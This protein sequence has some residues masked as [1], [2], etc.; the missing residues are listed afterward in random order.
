MTAGLQRAT[1]IF[2]LALVAVFALAAIFAPLIAPYGFAQSA[3]DGVDF[4]RQQAPSAQ[5]WFGTSVRGE[6]VFSRVIWGARTALFVIVISLVLSLF[7]GVPLGLLSG[8]LGRWFDRVLVLF[9]DAMYAFP[10]LLLAIVVSIVVAGG[11]STSLGGVLSAAVA[12]TA[13]FV[14][15]YFRVVRNAT[16]SV[17]NE[18]Y[19]DAARVTGASTGRILF[20]HIFANVTQS[21]PVI[22]TLNGSEAILTLAGL[23][24]LG[25]GIEPT[26]AAEWGYDLNKALSDVSN[27]I[28]WTGIFP[29]FAIVLVV[30]G[31]TL[32]GESLNEVLNPVLRTRRAVSA[33]PGDGITVE[34]ADS[35]EIDSADVDLVKDGKETS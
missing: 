19:V 7:V 16:V 10:T 23:G 9:M 6:D 4:V 3:A 32:V 31:M 1:L 25:F 22:V 5:H 15:Q 35:N 34:G 26:Q 13:V 18:P 27:G 14:P 29:G 8:Y 33:A 17:K 12:I 30:L 20:R 28:W 24:F 2:G 11:R 21:L